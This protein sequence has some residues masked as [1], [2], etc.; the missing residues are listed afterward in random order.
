V[1]SPVSMHPRGFEGSPGVAHRFSILG[2]NAAAAA[3]AVPIVAALEAPCAASLPAPLRATPL[4]RA[5][6]ACP[7]DRLAN[8]LAEAHA[9]LVVRAGGTAR[10]PRSG[11]PF[12]PK[13]Q[14]Q[15]DLGR[16]R[17]TSNPK[18]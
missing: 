13:H 9:L 5:L 6:A 16:H 11:L 8:R 4:G 7:P 12:R 3:A 15:V 1:V 10:A 18:L 14:S 2:A 17:V